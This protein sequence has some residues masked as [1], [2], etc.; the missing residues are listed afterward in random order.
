VQQAQ[1]TKIPSILT[2]LLHTINQTICKNGSISEYHPSTH[3]AA[4]LLLLKINKTITTLL[5]NSFFILATKQN[6]AQC[7]MGAGFNKLCSQSVR[8]SA[9]SAFDSGV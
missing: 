8:P 2:C 6:S 3:P 9:S 7:N 4:Q 1:N 5:Q